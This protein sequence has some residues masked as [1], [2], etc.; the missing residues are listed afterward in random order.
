MKKAFIILGMHRSGTSVL[1]RIVNLLGATVGDNL[2][3]GNQANPKGYW[4]HLDIVNIHNVLLAKLG[5]NWDSISPLPLDWQERDD[6]LLL[7][8][9]LKDIVVRDFNGQH[10]WCLKDP[11]MCRLLPLWLKIFQELEVVPYF[12]IAVRNPQEVASSLEVRNQISMSHS[13]LLWFRYVLESEYNSRGYKRIF[14]NFDDLIDE[15]DVCLKRIAAFMK[16][17]LSTPCKKKINLFVSDKLKHHIVSETSFFNKNN[18]EWIKAYYRECLAVIDGE[19]NSESEFDQLAKK[20]V[21]IDKFFSDIVNDTFCQITELKREN[22]DLRN[23][24]ARL[25]KQLDKKEAVINSLLRSTS[26]R[27]TSFVRKLKHA[28]L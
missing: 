9:Q 15:C 17:D 26:W 4:E 13:Y 16:V 5:L 27:V 21:F 28:F 23:D 7:K 22:N 14:I 11:R 3:Q 2:M 24:C 1:T 8:Q 10:I 20:L 25:K 19:K 6:I 12:I 18:P